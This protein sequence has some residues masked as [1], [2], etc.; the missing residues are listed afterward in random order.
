[1]YGRLVRTYQSVLWRHI[2]TIPPSTYHS[3]IPSM[4]LASSVEARRYKSWFKPISKFKRSKK[5]NLETSDNKPVII[6]EEPDEDFKDPRLRDIRHSLKS[7]DIPDGLR[8]KILTDKMTWLIE[9]YEFSSQLLPLINNVF[10]EL[11]KLNKYTIIDRNGGNDIM[12]EDAITELLKKSFTTLLNEPEVG[13]LPEYLLVLIQF[14]LTNDFPLNDS[15]LVNITLLASRLNYNNLNLKDT[16]LL[17][18]KSNKI[19]SHTFINELIDTLYLQGKL[20]FQVFEVLAD[21]N[22]TLSG[23]SPI[24]LNDNY[25][26]SLINYIESLYKDKSPKTHE[27]KNLESSIFRVQHCALKLIDQCDLKELKMETIFNLL[28]LAS[29]LQAANHHYDSSRVVN[30]LLD[31]LNSFDP[32]SVSDFFLRQEFASEALLDTFVSLI[33][34]NNYKVLLDELMTSIQN[35]PMFY[36]KERLIQSKLYFTEETSEDALSK[37]AIDTISAE[38]SNSTENLDITALYLK[39]LQIFVE[40]GRVSPNG[41]FTNEI[42]KFFKDQGMEV[43]LLAYKMRMDKAISYSNQQQAFEIFNDSGINLVQWSTQH[44]S[45]PQALKTLNDFIILSSEKIEDIGELF[46]LFI[47][48]KQQMVNDTANVFALTALSKRMLAEECVGDCIELLKREL[49]SIDRDSTLKLPTNEEFGFA[50]RQ[51]FD[52]LHEFVINYTN[53]ETYETNWVLYGE[54]H[55]YFYVPFDSYLPAMKFFC[56]HDR[57]NAALIIF[58]Q[59]KRLYESH[60][61][62]NYLP[63]LKEMYVHLFRAF[64]DGLYEEGVEEIHEYL[65]MDVSLPRQDI[66]LVNSVLNAYSN[67]QDVAKARDIFLSLS[68]LQQ[69]KGIE[70]A[71]EETVQIMLKTYTYAD[72]NYVRSFWNNLSSM[73]ILPNYDIFKQYLIAHVYH[74][75]PEDAIELTKEMDD[76]GL[77]VKE[78]TLVSMYNLCL[79]SDNQ[80]KIEQWAQKEYLNE[81]NNI[82]SKNLLNRSDDYVPENNI[83]VEGNKSLSKKT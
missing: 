55:K 79:S 29:D 26:T 65:K 8:Q 42:T 32:K 59:I 35:K 58:R 1:M 37:H 6:E 60:G 24:K 13:A 27:Y 14:S 80:D 82:V 25:Y 68:P 72:I 41:I 64:G 53:E 63:P 11:Y 77:E 33:V 52:T 49:P 3:S 46:N 2:P 48:I 7:T 16:L 56:H 78:D 17:L 9:E 12:S 43:P 10:M 50:Y 38:I 15:M 47:V 22:S 70:G 18:V 28:K 23:N 57:L 74:G 62:H 81:W 67:L 5:T 39:V 40:A 21:L 66:E 34:H 30:K 83:L 69:I 75:L 44:E 51:L 31:H 36:L 20:K 19:T 73:G 61:N 54:L 4:L 45:N 71:N 76:Y